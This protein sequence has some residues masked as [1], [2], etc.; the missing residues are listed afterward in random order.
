MATINLG[1]IKPVFK[2]AYAS[3]TAYVVDDIVV[4]SDESYICI[5]AGT[6]Q[7]PSSAT[8][9]W[10]KMAAKG[11]NGS[12]GTDLNS[13]LTTRGDI[14][15]KGA[16]ALTRLPKGTAGYYLKQGANDPE[17]GELSGGDYVK[18]GSITASNIGTAS[19]NNLFSSDYKVYKIF[20]KRIH[21]D[22]DNRAVRVR[23]RNGSGQISSSVYKNFHQGG[24]FGSGANTSL[25]NRSWNADHIN[26]T[27]N[28]LDALVKYGMTAEFTLFEPQATDVHKNH[29]CHMTHDVYDQTLWWNYTAGGG[30]IDVGALT[31][32]DFFMSAGN[33]N[34]IFTLYGLKE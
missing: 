28:G 27:L 26:L 19:F 17:W 5:Q 7:T 29:I 30:F 12:N 16:S 4:Y 23:Y 13:T 20:M 6:G 10:T 25:L 24:Y 32:I 11:T 9:Y 22:S 3:N 34:G 31:G 8:A 2:G 21:G 14:V 1:R 15:F 18:L 33:I